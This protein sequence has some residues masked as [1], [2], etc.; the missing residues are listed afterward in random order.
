MKKFSAI[1]LTCLFLVT[2]AFSLTACAKNEPIKLNDKQATFYNNWLSKIKDDTPI[3]KIAL[4]GS[5]DSG[6]SELHSIYKAM[7]ITQNY[8]IGE[9]LSF[10]CRYFDIRVNKKKNG[11]L[12]IFHGPDTSGC[13]FESIAKDIV[14]F[15]QSNKSEFL[16][17]DFQHF[18]NDSQKDVIEALKDT[19]LL[20]LAI[21]NN[22][23]YTD[24]DFIASLTL[25]DVRG[26]VVITWGNNSANSSDYPYLF[27]RNND[28]C[29]IEN[30]VLDSLYDE[31]ENKKSTEEFIKESLP[32]YMEHI[33]SN[34]NRITILQGQLT[35]P[36]LL[37]NLEKL[38][39]KHNQNMSNFIR[40]MESN[41]SYLNA[42]NII[43]RDFVGSDLEK[44]NCVLHLNISKGIVKSEMT[45]E[46]EAFTKAQL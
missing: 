44:T 40:N 30:A 39:K 41:A 4:L 35:L 16:I 46:F 43:M 17:L 8:T 13:S 42:I 19:G 24:L 25:K 23:P 37:G 29:T 28:S 12:N 14:A 9:Q 10:G 3:T 33:L 20:D 11:E 21:Q 31:V 36:S 26:K 27:R 7:T 22:T 34:Q 5:H 6:T 38:E 45:T 18:K 2:V 15:M 1:F 32:K